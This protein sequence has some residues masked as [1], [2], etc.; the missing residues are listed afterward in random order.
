[1]RRIVASAPLLFVPLAVVAC[2]GPKSY[3]TTVEVIQVERFG[4]NPPNQ[5]GLELRYSEC[6]GDVRGVIRGDKGFAEC[7]PNIK[8]GAKL[9]AEITTRYNAD[10]GSWR[11]E[12]TNLGECSL[13][14]DPKE[15]ANFEMVQTC[16][17]IKT[18]GV[19][20]GVRCDKTRNKELVAKC[21]WLK[22]R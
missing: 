15:E 12:I 6:P 21:P 20:V 3:V 2:D 18:T 19:V 16:S 14:I 1:M 13:K 9:K 22:R 4:E 11:S 17:E 10:R 8:E 7:A 5:L